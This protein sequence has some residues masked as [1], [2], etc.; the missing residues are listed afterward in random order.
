MA[1]FV[2]SKPA[3]DDHWVRGNTYTIEWSGGDPV[4]YPSVLI[5]LFKGTA[6]AS[7]SNIGIGTNSAGSQSWAVP[8]N[9][10]IGTDY[11]ILVSESDR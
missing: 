2:V 10:T 5:Q 1:L 8:S 4:T 6:T 7:V 9:I 3:T 11:R